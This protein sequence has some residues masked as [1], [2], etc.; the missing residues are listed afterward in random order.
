M[1]ATHCRYLATNHPHHELTSP[2]LACRANGSRLYTVVVPLQFPRNRQ[3]LSPLQLPSLSQNDWRHPSFGSPSRQAGSPDFQ[4]SPVLQLP[5][6]PSPPRAATP[7]FNS[8]RKLIFSALQPPPLADCMVVLPLP[9]VPFA[10]IIHFT[11]PAR[12]KHPA[13]LPP[14]VPFASIIHFTPPPMSST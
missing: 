1:S 2:V 13:G 5:L 14:S 12:G 11:P 6:T 10:S 9:S 3:V 8:P 7:P 4:R